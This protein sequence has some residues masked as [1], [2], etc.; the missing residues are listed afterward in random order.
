MSSRS[1]RCA[2]TAITVYQQAWSVRRPPSCRYTPSCSHYT[3]EAISQYGLVRGS[4]LGI[5]RIGRCHPFHR[6]GYDPVPDRRGTYE[7]AGP[8]QLSAASTLN[9][10]QNR[11]L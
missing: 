4:W 11:S 1:A 2:V 5:K 8:S 6:G 10:S 7:P 3:A 9:I